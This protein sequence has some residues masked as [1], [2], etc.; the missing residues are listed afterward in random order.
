VPYRAGVRWEALFDDLE[1]QL[2]AAARSDLRADVHERTR[3]ERASVALADRVRAS[4][5]ERLRLTLRGGAV[6]EGAV[7]D[8]ASQWLLL[9]DGPTR[10]ALVPMGAIAAAAGL[11]PHVAPPAG[12]VE[13]RLTLGHALRA[14]ARDRA[15]V[16]VLCDGFEVAG[17]L[18]RVGADH[19]DLT[20]ATGRAEPLA[21]VLEAIRAVRSG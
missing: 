18:E 6:L 12:T 17:R 13:R 10:R 4:A 1:A 16:V 14:L 2:D 3:A 8:V 5:G 21:V 7:L 11:S 15:A 9:G 20:P 19:V